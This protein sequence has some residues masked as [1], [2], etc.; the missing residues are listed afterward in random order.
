MNSGWKVGWGH[1]FETLETDVG[2]IMAALDEPNL[3][4]CRFGKAL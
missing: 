2:H 4:L 3:G 1:L